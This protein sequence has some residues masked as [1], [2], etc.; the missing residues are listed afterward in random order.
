MLEVDGESGL[1]EARSFC[2]DAFFSGLASPEGHKQHLSLSKTRVLICS[3]FAL[4]WLEQK[5]FFTCV[6]VL[7]YVK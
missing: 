6:S 5:T 7:P 4:W 1:G 3:V 2:L